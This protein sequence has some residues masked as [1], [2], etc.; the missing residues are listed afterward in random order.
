MRAQQLMSV[1]QSMAMQAQNGTLAASTAISSNMITGY[2]YGQLPVQMQMPMMGSTVS[3]FPPFPNFFGMPAAFPGMMPP[4]FNN[5]MNAMQQYPVRAAP[6]A[7]GQPTLLQ[8][9]GLSINESKAPSKTNSQ[10]NRR[11][12]Q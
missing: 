8:Q 11:R 7:I 12:S 6:S 3:A 1:M 4:F 10:H 5:N 2:P 9:A